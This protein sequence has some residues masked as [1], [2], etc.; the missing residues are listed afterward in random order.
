MNANFALD[1]KNGE[2]PTASRNLKV[3]SDIF[4]DTE[5]LMWYFLTSDWVPSPR[6][7]AIKTP[8]VMKVVPTEVFRSH[9]RV[10]GRR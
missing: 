5:I 7:G 4:L 10:Q 8:N 9:Q 2:F 1:C 6:W 3:S